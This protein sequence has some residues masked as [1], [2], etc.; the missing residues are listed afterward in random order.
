MINGL[1]LQNKCLAMLASSCLKKEE[2]PLLMDGR[3]GAVIRERAFIGN[4]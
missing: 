2:L 4:D 1:G 3:M